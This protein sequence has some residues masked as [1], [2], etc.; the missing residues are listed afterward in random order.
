MT[1]AELKLAG[2]KHLD[3]NLF[4]VNIDRIQLAD[5]STEEDVFSFMNPRHVTTNPQGFSKEEMSELRESIRTLGLEHPLSLRLVETEDAEILQLVSGERRFRCISK[6]IKDKTSCFDPATNS[7][8]PAAELYGAV[9]CRINLL[10]D[11]DAFKLAF[12]ENDRSIGIGEGATVALIRNF[13]REGWTDQQILEVSGKSITWLKDTDVLI[14]LDEDTFTALTENTINR[15]AALLLAKVDDVEERLVLLDNAKN[16]AI[17]RLQS[18]K[19]KLQ[20]ELAAAE[21]K[22]EIAEAELVVAETLGDED[23]VAEQA[24]IAA[25]HTN[26]AKRKK[27]ELASIEETTPKATAIDIDAARKTRKRP[28]AQPADG[29]SKAL[30]LPKLQKYWYEPLNKLITGVADDPEIDLDDVRLVCLLLEK[31]DAGE[32]DIL[33]VLRFHEAN[34]ESELVI[35]ETDDDLEDEEDDDSS[36]EE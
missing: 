10:S 32:R 3:R 35:V 23:K 22:E 6:L 31:I 28:G 36:D 18:M 24:A 2:V 20:K 12:S 15:S 14:G 19:K 26:R 8:K 1:V 33:S 7:W 25:N 16:S 4:R 29:T 30:T 27:Q 5:S 13:R 9:E 21:T 11:Q 34:K 17:E